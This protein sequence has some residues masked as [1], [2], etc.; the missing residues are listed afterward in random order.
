MG[1]EKTI[2][3]R[4]I[5]TYHIILEETKTGIIIGRKDVGDNYIEEGKEYLKSIISGMKD[6][7]FVILHYT[8]EEYDARI[9]VR[10]NCYENGIECEEVVYRAN[11][12][13]ISKMKNEQKNRNC[14]LSS[15]LEFFKLK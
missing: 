9:L 4:L 14:G 13:K 3:E 15:L 2:E 8:D 5:P 10:K 12:Y 6:H 7:K 1:T 11:F